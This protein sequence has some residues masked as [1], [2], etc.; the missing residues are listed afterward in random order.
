LIPLGLRVALRHLTVLPLPYDAAEASAAPAQALAWF[1]LVGLGIGLCVAGALA[2][3]FPAAVRAVLALTVWIALS[4]ALHED[5][6]MDSADAAL[7]PVPRER[8]L[9]IL[10][11]PRVGAFAVSAE[12][13]TLL[14]RAAAL[15]AG[16]VFAP[17][18][19]ALTGR[20]VMTL[21]LALWAPAR[22]DGL[23]ARWAEGAR[24]ALPTVVALVLLVAVAA[25]ERGALGGW[26]R[27]SIS[28]VFGLAGG[29]LT[30]SWLNRRFGGLTGDAHGAAAVVAE[31]AAL[32]AY[33]WGARVARAS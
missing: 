17:V 16:T 29:L 19:A 5:G 24:T 32:L 26:P 31:C 33:A 25:V 9:E 27:S 18:V 30:A 3:P 21:S 22:P 11:D 12:A 4:G 1:P 8:R 15:A 7:A 13:L 23:G 20:W 28:A 6:L 2:L 10:Q 14:V